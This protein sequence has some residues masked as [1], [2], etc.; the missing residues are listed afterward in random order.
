MGGVTT[1]VASVLPTVSHVLY[2]ATTVVVTNM[3]VHVAGWTKGV[4]IA[5]GDGSLAAAKAGVVNTMLL[6]VLCDLSR[7]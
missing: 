4:G 1:C 7:N 3:S 5:K 6:P 2:V